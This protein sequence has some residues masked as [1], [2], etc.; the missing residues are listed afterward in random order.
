MRQL[1]IVAAVFIGL[2]CSGVLLGY[3]LLRRW[4]GLFHE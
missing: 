1:A 4:L 2:E 3:A